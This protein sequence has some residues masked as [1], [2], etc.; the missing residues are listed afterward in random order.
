MGNNTWRV[1]VRVGGIKFSKGYDNEEMAGNM[2]GY[3]RSCIE[4][5][6]PLFGDEDV[7]KNASLLA[8]SSKKRE[9]MRGPSLTELAAGTPVP[10]GS[11]FH[12]VVKMALFNA[13]VLVKSTESCRV[14]LESTIPS[15]VP[16]EYEMI[17][18][19]EVVRCGVYL[20]DKDVQDRCWRDLQVKG[21]GGV[22]WLP[23]WRTRGGECSQ[24]QVFG[25]L[26]L[27]SSTTLG[28]PTA[29]PTACQTKTLIVMQQGHMRKNGSG[30]DYNFSRGVQGTQGV[31]R[32]A[33]TMIQGNVAEWGMAVN[34]LPLF[35]DAMNFPEVLPTLTNKEKIVSAHSW[36]RM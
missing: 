28:T 7:V 3:L 2:A 13:C 22:M 16:I 12:V 14:K 20:Y 6:K 21:T 9:V 18:P 5:E 19:A 31:F 36:Y 29:T 26:G 25:D 24:V 30:V 17:M 32:D 35:S 23:H 11:K 10:I 33:L 27:Y 15:K 34:V 1:N 8:D 4:T